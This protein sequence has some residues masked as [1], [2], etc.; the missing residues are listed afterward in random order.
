MNTYTDSERLEFLSAHGAYISH[1]SDGENCN[2]WHRDDEGN[3]KP[4]QGYP[5]RCY[6]EHR[7]AID[8]CMDEWNARIAE[9]AGGRLHPTKQIR[10]LADAG[11]PRGFGPVCKHCGVAMV[12]DL[13]GPICPNQG[14]HG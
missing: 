12:P 8:A 10:R 1:S 9:I 6:P 5:Q 3:H 11:N 14:V 7:S 2:V 4:W 13:G